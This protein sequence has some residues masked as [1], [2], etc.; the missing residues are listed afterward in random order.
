MEKV[1]QEQIDYYTKKLDD[2]KKSQTF[3]KVILASD[4]ENEL[5]DDQIR[6]IVDFIHLLNTLKDAVM[7]ELTHPSH[8]E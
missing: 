4:K 2:L 7:I 8:K 1:F 3:G 6:L 5:V